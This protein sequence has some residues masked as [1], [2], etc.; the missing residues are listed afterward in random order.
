M[1]TERWL[2]A[3]FYAA[4]D[5]SRLMMLVSRLGSLSEAS[6]RGVEAYLGE[7][8]HF[9]SFSVQSSP[10]D[11]VLKVAKSS[12]TQLGERRVKQWFEALDSIKGIQQGG[13]VPPMKAFRHDDLILMAMP[14]GGCLGGE[15]STII[16]EKLAVTKQALGQL[17]LTLDDY[18]QVLQAVGVPFIIDWSDLEVCQKS[19]SYKE[20]MRR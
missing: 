14:K 13:L 5:E 11:L 9:Q 7:G 3:A 15:Q 8:A 12:F 19:L 10:I 17:G 1:D 20:S 18:P 16:Q 2:A 6:R 4:F